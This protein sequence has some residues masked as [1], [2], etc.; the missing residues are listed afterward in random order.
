MHRNPVE[1]NETSMHRRGRE[2]TTEI[3][4]VD[5]S[6]KSSSWKVNLPCVT[7]SRFISGFMQFTESQR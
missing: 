4:E 5:K 2:G 6:L 3:P 7:G 1:I